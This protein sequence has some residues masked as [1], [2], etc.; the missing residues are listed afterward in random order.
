MRDHADGAGSVNDSAQDGDAE[1]LICVVNG[2]DK[3]G[4]DRLLD[5]GARRT[6]RAILCDDHA[7]MLDDSS[8]G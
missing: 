5:E 1:H 3:P 6:V 8:A 2:C 4:T 7:D